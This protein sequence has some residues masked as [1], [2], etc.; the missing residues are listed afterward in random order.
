MDGDLDHTNDRNVA[1]LLDA[2][3]VPEET[4]ELTASRL[5]ALLR[6]ELRRKHELE[7]QLVKLKVDIRKLEAAAKDRKAAIE[8]QEVTGESKT[9]SSTEATMQCLGANTDKMLQYACSVQRKRGVETDDYRDEVTDIIRKQ[10]LRRAGAQDAFGVTKEK[11]MKL[12][13]GLIV[14]SAT[15]KF[16]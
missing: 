2:V 7:T 3:D 4:T 5:Q 12:V 15:K 1:A 11:T 8:V 6:T 13:S 14:K 10:I 16:G 9:L